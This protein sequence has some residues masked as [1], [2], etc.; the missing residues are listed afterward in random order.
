MKRRN[1]LLGGTGLAV[2]SAFGSFARRA[3]AS[4]APDPSRLNGDLTP[5]GGERAASKSGLVPAWTGGITTPPAGWTPDMAP[6]DLFAS[7]APLFTVTPT[8]MSQYVDL[9]SDGQMQALKK[10]GA[11][12]FKLNVYP[13][14]RT[15]SA[16][17]YVYDNA[18]KNVTGAQP[19][20]EGLVYGFTG[21]V[22]GPPFPILSDDPSIAGTQAMWNHLTRWCGEFSAWVD[23]TFVVGNNQRY[24][25]NAY[26]LLQMS[27]YYD[28]T[29]TAAKFSG[30]YNRNYLEYVAP[31]NQVGGKFM[32][33]Y[34]LQP[35]K[36]QNAAYEY[37]VG[38]G[39]IRQAPNAE[40]DT[41]ATQ[42]GDA[43]NYDEVYLFL[44]S[45]DR[46]NW[47][48][49]GK[50]E[51][52]VPY[53]Q[54]KLFTGQVNDVLGLQFLNPDLIRYEVHRCWVVEGHLA[55]GKRMTDPVRRFYIDEDTWTALMSDLYD[56]QGNYW[57]F[58]QQF[59]EVHP[60]LPGTTTVAGGYLNFQEAKY[61][62][63]GPFYNAP[64]PLGSNISFSP[65]P[66]SQFNPQAMATSGGL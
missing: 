49:V 14:A 60:Q 19:V 66:A 47:K 11:A 9:L 39:R 21:A 33:S 26:K 65:I 44:G 29:M 64:V 41:P 15:A 13:A 10:F 43:I 62:Y 7:Q 63:T 3:N 17:Q 2:A 57:R 32:P 55:P 37:L 24:L 5:L 46:Y 48:L 34:S 45:L 30:F 35:D 8:N 12:G 59:N 1:A 61:V 27:P 36:I 16:P 58:G 54:H 6:P 18:V 52:I 56:D 40:Y 42:F 20:G 53:N 23:S 51:M 31:P 25:T 28:P 50:K 38:L 4:S 22:G